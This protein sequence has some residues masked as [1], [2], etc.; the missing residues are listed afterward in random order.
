MRF[1]LWSNN[2]LDT[3]A[4]KSSALSEVHD[5]CRWTRVF[6]FCLNILSIGTFLAPLPLHRGDVCFL[7]PGNYGPP[8]EVV[9]VSGRPIQHVS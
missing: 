9:Y 7:C 4:V 2:G 5:V 3:G 6:F 1:P 8:S